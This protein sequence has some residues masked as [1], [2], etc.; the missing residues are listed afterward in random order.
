MSVG[1]VPNEKFTVQSVTARQQQPIV[2][3]E[4]EETY[5]V[6]MLRKPINRLLVCEVPDY[7]IRV[8]SALSRGKEHAIVRNSEAGDL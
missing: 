7:D 2:V 5:L 8:F 1:S 6:V 4:S 3:G